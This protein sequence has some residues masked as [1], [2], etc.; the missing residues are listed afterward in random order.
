MLQVN[1]YDLEL[2]ITLFQQ[3]D[4]RGL[5]YIHR[6][7]YPLT[8]YY[9]NLRL[10]NHPLAEEIA[11]SA[12]LKIWHRHSQFAHYSGV[13][14]YL[15]KIVERDCQRVLIKARKV[16]LFN[17]DLPEDVADGSDA[18]KTLVKAETYTLL[19]KAIKKLSPGMQAV[20]NSMYIE[21]NNLTETAKLLNLNTSTVHTQKKR[22]IKALAKLLP[23]L[24]IAIV[25]LSI[26]Y[27]II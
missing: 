20:V 7:L 22:A 18:F 10:H 19:H 8:V 21:G 13:K 3:G 11:S 27:S 6:Q 5:H 14:A 2:H 9:A 23:G 26:L 12:F 17:S 16:A 15:L 24:V 4:E 25:L 1:P